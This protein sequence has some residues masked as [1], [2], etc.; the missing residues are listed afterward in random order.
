MYLL[1]GATV[2]PMLRVPPTNRQNYR[3]QR[4]KDNLRFVS[5]VPVVSVQH[6]VPL[7]SDNCARAG[8]G[9]DAA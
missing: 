2:L 6:R 9:L 1:L 3:D 4:R 7:L 5:K 8:L